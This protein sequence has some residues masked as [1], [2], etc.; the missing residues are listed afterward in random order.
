MPLDE[1]DSNDVDARIAEAIRESKQES[2]AI[3][4]ASLK[5]PAFFTDDPELWFVRI[6]AQFR[7]KAITQDETKFDYICGALDG[8][9]AKDVKKA[10]KNPPDTNKYE[11]LKTAL[12]GVFGQ[13]QAQKDAALLNMEGLG[14]QTASAIWRRIESLNEDPA[15]LLRA[16][17]LD[18]LPTEVRSTLA[19]K[20]FESMADMVKAA[21]AILEARR[22]NNQVA[23]VGVQPPQP[24]Q[25]QQPQEAAAIQQQ[26][27]PR[28][29]QQGQKRTNNLCYFHSRWGKDARNC[30]GDWCLAHHL[31]RPQG[32]PS[33]DRDPAYQGNAQAGR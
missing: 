20:T 33:G 19:V 31:P 9:I 15:T 24:Y 4:A 22:L 28:Q 18:K 11:N 10:L 7:T 27:Q 26:R 13:T 32:R 8:T 5:I 3:A 12:L 14:D 6:E 16:V 1:D 2:Q 17:F 21:D 25:A 23:Q 30:V 29:Q